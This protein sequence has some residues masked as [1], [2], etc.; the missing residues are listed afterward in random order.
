[1][2]KHVKF[3]LL[4]M[5]I[6]LLTSGCDEI[7]ELQP[8][9][10]ITTAPVE[11]I[12]DNYRTYYEIFL[13]SF[14]DSNEDGTGDINGLIQKLDYLNDGDP[15]TNT[16][17][18]VTGIWLMPIMSGASYHKYDVIDYDNIDA[19]FGTI[20]DF[21]NLTEQC[22]HRNIKVIMDFV[23]NH[24]SNQHPWFQEA[25]T[26]LRSL[27]P[28]EEPKVEDCKYVAYYIFV[29][30][31]QDNPKYHKVEHTNWY[32]EGVF[33]G[34]MPDLN[35]SSKEVRT[36]IEQII[37]FWF[38]TG[39]DGFRLDAAKEYYSG[40]QTK[41]IEVLTW[42]NDYVKSQKSD[43][44]LV[45]EVWDSFGTIAS[46]YES[47]IDS[48]F[49]YAFGGSSGK[50]ALC[51]NA[52]GNQSVGYNLATNIKQVQDIL[53]SR[54]PSYIDASFISN[55]DNNRAA[56][57][58]GN[59][60]DKVKLMGGINLMMNGSSFIYYGE[61]IGMNGTGRDENK[62]GPM[63]WLD[64]DTTGMTQGPMH[65]EKQAQSFSC[66]EVQEKDPTSILNYYKQAIRLRNQHPELLRGSIQVMENMDRE[67]CA[68]SKTWNEQT[69]YV[70]M[71][72]GKKEKII[73][74]PNEYSF[75][76][77]VGT[78]TTS[79][80]QPIIDGHKVILPSY[81]IVILK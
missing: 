6:V 5:V 35:L 8:E 57:F 70:L 59:E 2:R 60:K 29:K 38:A 41:N 21:K 16:D 44:Y 7:V 79:E 15:E 31:K 27:K 4:C 77:L 37:D 71:N 73:E 10:P 62:R 45:A 61:E 52:V 72:L 28:E 67:I 69:I 53:S 13:S 66:V 12:D 64:T 20:D 33:V 22:H 18:E 42:L 39:V 54:N 58:V 49:N 34:D 50:I 76:R 26:Y 40:S 78:L 9:H 47:G 36:E 3:A 43:A 48:I 11:I 68:V 30:D 51:V 17:L 19:S 24:T 65:M 1:M 23:I 46:Y 55:H 25:V 80:Q 32:Y 63:Y 74:V 56:S 14:Y 81:A 75:D